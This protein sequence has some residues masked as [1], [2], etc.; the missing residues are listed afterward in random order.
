VFLEYKITFNP[1]RAIKKC[2]EQL[3]S[4]HGVYR[5][6]RPDSECRGV[7]IVVD[8][9]SLVGLPRV[10]DLSSVPAAIDSILRGNEKLSVR[11][12]SLDEVAQ[13]FR[14]SQYGRLLS[15]ECLRAAYNNR[16]KSD[17]K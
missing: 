16:L 6:G 15:P 9:G 8:C 2:R 11:I 7:G 17:S 3:H 12:V 13:Y 10:A 1:E 4:A 14:R 5:V